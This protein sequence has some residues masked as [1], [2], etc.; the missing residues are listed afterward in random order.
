ML[1]WQTWN[2]IFMK[3]S[4]IYRLIGI[5]LSFGNW[6]SL[7]HTLVPTP[8]MTILKWNIYHWWR[9]K[10][11][12]KLREIRAS[13]RPH[14]HAISASQ[15]KRRASHRERSPVGDLPC[16]EVPRTLGSL[17]SRPLGLKQG[18]SPIGDLSLHKSFPLYALTR[19]RR[20]PR[21]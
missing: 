13:F 16:F 19:T 9:L 11:V 6:L 3:N 8:L 2:L 5:K 18:R 10:V 14:M 20:K 7:V 1:N 21:S 4:R 15:V 12:D 17:P